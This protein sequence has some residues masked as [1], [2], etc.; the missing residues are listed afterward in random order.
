MTH[1]WLSQTFAVL[2]HDPLSKV[3]NFPAASVHT[4][5]QNH[6]EHLFFVEI[7]QNII[8]VLHNYTLKKRYKLLIMLQNMPIKMKTHKSFCRKKQY[9][10]KV[11]RNSPL[12]TKLP[13]PE[14]PVSLNI[15]C[16]DSTVNAKMVESL[17]PVNMRPCGY[18]S[19]GGRQQTLATKLLCPVIQWP[20]LKPLLPLKKET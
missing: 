4:R 15:G 14:C 17:L 2:S 6:K 19:S 7:I 10:E 9:E 11:W 18:L 5:K 20:S 3:P 16:G 8:H 13:V 1:F 12:Q